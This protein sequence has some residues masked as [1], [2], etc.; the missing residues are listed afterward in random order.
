MAF[1]TI[2]FYFQ[3]REAEA[4]CGSADLGQLAYFLADCYQLLFYW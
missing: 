4:S 3:I 1:I 2:D